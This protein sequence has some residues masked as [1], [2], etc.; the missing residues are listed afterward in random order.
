LSIEQ[1]ILL[2][3]EADFGWSF[4]LET[5]ASISRGTYQDCSRLNM[6]FGH[7]A[8]WIAV[9]VCSNPSQGE[10]TLNAWSPKSF[11]GVRGYENEQLAAG[12]HERAGTRCLSIHS[13]TVLSGYKSNSDNWLQQGLSELGVEN[14]ES[15]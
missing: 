12:W 7:V 14:V 9:T 10:L 2:K 11:Q 15:A 13:A 6:G 4:G 8:P 1:Q 5:A 3:H